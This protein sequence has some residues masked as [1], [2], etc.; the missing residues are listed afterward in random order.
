M[1]VAVVAALGLGTAG[2]QAAED[3]VIGA[4]YPMTGNNAPQGADARAALETMADIINTTHAPIPMLRA[5]GGLRDS[6]ARMS[7]SSSPTT[8]ATRRRRAPRPSASSRRNMRSR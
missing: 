5:G 3:V 4:I 7:A 1:G 8:R 2:A 6:A